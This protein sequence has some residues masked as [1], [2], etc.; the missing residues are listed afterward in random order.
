MEYKLKELKVILHISVQKAEFELR[1]ISLSVLGKFPS[2]KD[3][4]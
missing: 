3:L 1:G 2:S 4:S